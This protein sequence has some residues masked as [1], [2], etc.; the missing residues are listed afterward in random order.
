[1]VIMLYSNVHVFAPYLPLI[2]AVTLGLSSILIWAAGVRWAGWE[3]D[4]R[5]AMLVFTALMIFSFVSIATLLRIYRPRRTES[6]L[7]ELNELGGIAFC[8]CGIACLGAET[9]AGGLPG[10]IYGSC[11]LA[12]VATLVVLRIGVR[13]GLRALRRRGK[14][15]R[16]WLLIGR[17]RRSAQIAEQILAHPHFGIRIA[18]VVDLG[19][20]DVGSPPECATPFGRAPLNEL[21][22][23][24]I[25]EVDDL[26]SILTDRNIDEVVVFLP[27]RSCYDRVMRILKICGEAGISTMLSPEAFERPANGTIDF[28]S[29]GD[30]RFL[31]R[32][33]G[34]VNMAPLMTKRLMDTLFAAAALAVFLPVCLVIAMAIKLDS[35]GPVFFCHARVGLHGRLFRMIKF[36]TMD[37]DAPGRRAA[38]A[39]HNEIDGPAFKVRDDPRVTRVGRWL[40][41]RHLDELPQLWNVL[42]GDM[43]LVGPRPLP[44]EEVCGTE[45]W[46]RR[47]HS[48]PPGMTCLWQAKGNHD[49]TFQRWMELDLEYID[50]WSL[51]M[52]LRLILVTM[53]TVARGS[54]W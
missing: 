8:A 17:N 49:L 46:Q 52:D 31:A 51:L 41:K 29:F 20:S 22:Q 53:K 34:P 33:S 9:V 32:S 15:Y 28:A 45:W 54:G 23:R 19:V 26:R 24:V 44:P 42:I 4:T 11:A 27:I 13:A 2:D 37:A 3:A 48:M 43:S 25:P 14:D 38:L 47:R 50:R 39:S 7:R 36:R 21:T 6:A 10:V 12:A 35:K 40:R 1:L 16:T 5:P 30:V 18:E